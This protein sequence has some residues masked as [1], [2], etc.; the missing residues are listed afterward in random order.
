MRALRSLFF[1]LANVLLKN[2]VGIAPVIHQ[3]KLAFVEAA[4][5]NHGRNGAPATTNKIATLT[6]MSRSHVSD[7]LDE[8]SADPCTD[9]VAS[10]TESQVLAAWSSN[11]DYIDEFGLPRVLDPGPGKGT[12]R[13]LV[14]ETVRDEDADEQMERLL[15]SGSVRRRDDGR[16]ELT[17]RM[18][19]LVDDLPRIISVFL[20]PLASVVD[21]NWDVP[22]GDGFLIRVAHSDRVNSKKIAMIRRIATEQSVLLLEHID[23]ELTR[24]EEKSAEPMRNSD[25]AE[26]SRIGIGV[27]YFEQDKL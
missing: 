25:G 13:T 1:P 8:A 6:G 21:K 17:Q 12:Y 10:L 3:L 4:K 11:E 14:A 16:Y 15:R 22:V 19:P 24:Y 20:S 9:E 7:L 26:L 5:K 23:D 2:K 18:F 27:Y